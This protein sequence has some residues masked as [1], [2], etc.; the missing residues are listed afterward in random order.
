MEKKRTVRKRKIPKK[1]IVVF[2]DAND[3]V[4]KTLFV[5]DGSDASPPPMKSIQFETKHHQIIFA[6]WD[7]D[8]TSI[9]SELY[10]VAQAPRP[11]VP[12]E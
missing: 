5:E 9:H 3:K 1:H 10:C 7:Q 12:R 6:G 11:F 8:L 2:Q 4:F